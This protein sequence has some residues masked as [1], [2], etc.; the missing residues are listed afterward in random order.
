MTRQAQNSEHILGI[1]QEYDNSIVLQYQGDRVVNGLA[2]IT[3]TVPAQPHYTDDRTRYETVLGRLTRQFTSGK[4]IIIEYP[5]NKQPERLKQFADV[6]AFCRIV[7]R[8]YAATVTL[9]L[10]KM[11]GNPKHGVPKLDPYMVYL[12]YVSLRAGGAVVLPTSVGNIIAAASPRGLSTMFAVKN[13]PLSKAGVVLTTMDQLPSLADIPAGWDGYLRHMHSQGILTGSKL[14]RNNKHSLLRN[15]PEWSRQNSMHEHDG[16]SMFVFLPGPYADVTA[17]ILASEGRLLTASSAN[18]SGQGNNRDIAKLHQDIK[19][20]C[21]FVAW[22]AHAVEAYPLDEAHESQG[23]MVDFR[24]QKN[25]G[26]FHI[27]RFGFMN[28]PFITESVAYMRAR[29]ELRV[30]RIT[31]DIHN[32][33]ATSNIEL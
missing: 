23:V 21:D 17:R 11:T 25:A 4:S 1:Y 19:R 18:K 7:D 8:E 2:E 28:G 32:V 20:G 13:R 10:Q 6:M 16:T 31:A 5:D 26:K 9:R 3:M 12:S 22:D 14:R 15:Q 33:A 24:P 30:P 29:P 27:I